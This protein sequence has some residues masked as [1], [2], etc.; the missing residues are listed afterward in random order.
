[1]AAFKL[2]VR[3]LEATGAHMAR[4]RNLSGWYFK[5]IPDA[6]RWRFEA[7]ACNEAD[8]YIALADRAIE[9]YG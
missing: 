5:G 1:M 4:A 8:E 6:A 2:H 7:M 3:L 9:L